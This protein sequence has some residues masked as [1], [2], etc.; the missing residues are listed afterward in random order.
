MKLRS[1]IPVLL[2]A[3]S[4]LLRA[5]MP[6]SQPALNSARNAPAQDLLNMTGQDRGT[7][8][9]KVS[10]S[11]RLN[12]ELPLDA[13]F[14]D[15]TGEEKPLRAFFG[16]RPVVMALVYYQ[17]P[18]L[19][20]QVLTGLVRAARVLNFTPGKDYD[21]VVVS[22]DSR[23]TPAQAAE[24]KAFYTKSFGHPE[25]NGAWHFLVGNPESVKQITT[26]VGFNYVWDVHTAQFAHA[27]AI[28]LATPEGKLSKY[29]FGVDYSPKDLR[30]ALVEAS[31][32]RIGSV[33]DQVLL[34]CYHFD[35]QAAKYTP[36]A[37]GMLRLAGGATVLGLGLFMFVM[38]KRDSRQK[39]IRA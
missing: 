23:E 26:A 21:V 11:Q 2:M 12:T 7:P 9:S 38:L 33:V 25:T 31:E 29:F 27:S 17:C 39:G 36:Y 20:S 4:A 3:A 6:A 10:I 19:C 37:M 1:S 30:F 5:D 14:K 22:F 35:E 32:N 16:K 8:L 15:E 24:K 34:F 18:M 28:Y 13:V